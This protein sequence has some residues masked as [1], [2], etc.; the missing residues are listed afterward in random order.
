MYLSHAENLSLEDKHCTNFGADLMPSR[1]AS[2]S[3]LVGARVARSDADSG[4]LCTLAAAGSLFAPSVVLGS[5]HMPGAKG[6]SGTQAGSRCAAATCGRPNGGH[7]GW[8]CC[9]WGGNVDRVWRFIA[10]ENP[11]RQRWRAS[12]VC[13]YRDQSFGNDGQ[14]KVADCGALVGSSVHDFS[15]TKGM[16]EVSIFF[17]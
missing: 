15:M 16:A 9:G 5:M 17:G 4:R 7:L 11:A 13:V 12:A 2:G 6:S 10:A 8:I 14:S 1:S 3:P